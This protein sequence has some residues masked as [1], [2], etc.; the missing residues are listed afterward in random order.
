MGAIIFTGRRQYQSAEHAESSRQSDQSLCP[1][2]LRV[3]DRFDK[4]TVGNAIAYRTV[5][6]SFPTL[7]LLRS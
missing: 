5:S 7:R 4:Q 3:P 1:S 6:I 2:G